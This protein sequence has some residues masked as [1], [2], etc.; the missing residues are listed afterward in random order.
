[1]AAL[2]E[3]T[4]LHYLWEYYFAEFSEF[5]LLSYT[6]D[7]WKYIDEARSAKGVWEVRRRKQR[8]FDIRWD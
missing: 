6:H 7:T 4:G 8:E 3:Y 1:L 2:F 5:S